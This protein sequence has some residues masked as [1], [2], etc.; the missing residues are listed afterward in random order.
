[1]TPVLEDILPKLP[2]A[3]VFSVL[4]VKDGYWH[5]KL[6]PESSDLTAMSTPFGN[7]KWVRLPMGL[8]PSSD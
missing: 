4:D 6:S 2:G 1:M 5:L 3:R 7:F 8:K